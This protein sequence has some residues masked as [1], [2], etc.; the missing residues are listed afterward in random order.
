MKIKKWVTIEQEVEVEVDALEMVA[1][2]V[3]E[4]D[5]ELFTRAV[6][7]A[8]SVLRSVN[9]ERLN[10]AITRIVVANALKMEAKR[11]EPEYGQ[12]CSSFDDFHNGETSRPICPRQVGREECFRCTKAINPKL[13]TEV[14]P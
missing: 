14:T 7:R 1:A 3:E 8:V 10:S 6:S 13:E 5:D 11:Y 12:T 2:I 9:P 4:G